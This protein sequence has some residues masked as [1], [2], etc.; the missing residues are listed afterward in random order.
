M[1]ESP[2]SEPA[3]GLAIADA[4]NDEPINQ[5]ALAWEATAP[6]EGLRAMVKRWEPLYDK[7][8]DRLDAI[9]FEAVGHIG[10]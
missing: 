6:P 7:A 8:G 2:Q 10:Q 5:A 3:Q 1:P 9:G 4:L